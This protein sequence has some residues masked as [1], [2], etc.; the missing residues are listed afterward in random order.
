MH[1]LRFFATPEVERRAGGALTI[2]VQHKFY[3]WRKVLVK[4]G[5]QKTPKACAVGE[6]IRKRRYS[7]ESE[8]A[9]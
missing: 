8:T 6:F 5:R 3:L 4:L 1:G 7:Y 2:S 9:S